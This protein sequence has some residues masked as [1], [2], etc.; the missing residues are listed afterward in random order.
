MD[1]P[2]LSRRVVS[3][4]TGVYVVGVIVGGISILNVLRLAEKHIDRG[5]ELT[6]WSKVQILGGHFFVQNGYFL[7]ALSSF[8]L[9]SLW[10]VVGVQSAFRQRSPDRGND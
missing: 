5:E 9:I 2:I 7:L 8:V 3:A 6:A 1:L 4:I 10:V